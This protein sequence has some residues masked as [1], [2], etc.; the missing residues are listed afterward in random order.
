MIALLR[1]FFEPFGLL[2]PLSILGTCTTDMSEFNFRQGQ[3]L[4]TSAVR[5]S[6]FMKNIHRGLDNPEGMPNPALLD[7]QIKKITA[8]ILS[9]R[10]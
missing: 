5:E 6:M 10:K 9:L 8:Y 1:L 7:Y 3:L 2:L 4:G